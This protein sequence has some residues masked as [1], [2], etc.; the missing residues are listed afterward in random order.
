[1]SLNL[2]LSGGYPSFQQTSHMQSANPALVAADSHP[3]MFAPH[4]RL[5]VNGGYPTFQQHTHVHQAHNIRSGIQILYEHSSPGAAYNSKD[6]Y[7][8]P[9][10]HPNTRTGL[11]NTTRDWGQNGP[12]RIMWLYGS[13]G[14][15]KSAVAQTMS[16]EF[17]AKCNLAAS[18]FF[19]R[20]APLD[21]HRGHEGRFVATIAYQLTE[22]VP[23]LQRYVEQVV[24]NRPSVFDL[25]LSEQVTALII[26]PLK[27][28][29]LE[30]GTSPFM[31]PRVIVVDGLDE[32]KEESGQTQVLE[33]IAKLVSYQDI[34]PC[35]VFLA[36][37]PELVIRSWMNNKQSKLPHLLRSISLL[38]HCDSDHDI[39]V[40]VNDE[41]AEL[42]RSHPLTYLIPDDWPSFEFVEEIVKRASGQ[43]IYAST[44]MK[45]I[46]DLRGNP[47]DRLE[48]ILCNSIPSYDRP[49][50][51]LDALYL[52]IL[53]QTQY[54]SLV[55]QILAFRVSTTTF[56]CWISDINSRTHLQ[57]VLSLPF[58]VHTLLIDLQSILNY[59]SDDDGM[60]FMTC[61][62]QQ[63]PY[64]TLFHHASLL[65]FLLDPH[66]SEEF[67][68]DVLHFD[69]ELCEITL[70]HLGELGS[71]VADEQYILYCFL[72]LLQTQTSC[73]PSYRD[74]VITQLARWDELND[75]MLYVTLC[76]LAPKNA[77]TLVDIIDRNLWTAF[78]PAVARMGA[79]CY[80]KFVNAG[81][82][83]ELF[84]MYHT[85][86]LVLD[87]RR[88]LDRDL[89]PHADA[90]ESFSWHVMDC[91]QRRTGVDAWHFCSLEQHK[92]LMHIY[93]E[94]TW[95][96]FMDVLDKYLPASEKETLQIEKLQRDAAFEWKTLALAVAVFSIK[97]LISMLENEAV[98][99]HVKEKGGD[100][101][102]AITA[103]FLLEDI[104]HFI[105][106]Y[107]P[108]SADIVLALEEISQKFF[109]PH[110]VSTMEDTTFPFDFPHPESESQKELL[111]S[112]SS[113]CV[114]PR[115]FFLPPDFLHQT[116]VGM[117]RLNLGC[118]HDYIRL[119]I[120]CNGADPRLDHGFGMSWM[121][122]PDKRHRDDGYEPYDQLGVGACE[123]AEITTDPKTGLPIDFKNW[124][125][126][127]RWYKFLSDYEMAEKEHAELKKRDPSC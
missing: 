44:I 120:I 66:R 88:R 69:K 56:Y 31:L 34:F 2:T 103:A 115:W 41:A 18:F 45:Y 79:R 113:P 97:H 124:S 114:L 17:R 6:R 7:D 83:Q 20:T 28:L 33:A 117:I 90:R 64:P 127:E 70:Q 58:P 78:A 1:M 93:W 59:D 107:C 109:P 121:Y 9:K 13:A 24:L 80:Q 46:K 55:H 81:L 126:E 35:S 11:L 96:R 22:V 54:P 123:L 112:F 62:G 27:G 87:Y 118:L 3:A 16:M 26:D 111:R 53:R 36:S 23:G 73:H 38:D 48:A 74:K 76:Q 63:I 77:D 4:S 68:V 125:L 32:C 75:E 116:G 40:F 108:I 39:R 21:S 122:N 52:H 82:P 110:V 19:S 30:M 12:S 71:A 43:F 49:Y 92:F 60:Q 15:G 67:Y 29:Q 72:I 37:R 100:N 101:W 95:Q 10:C 14:A 106:Q 42:K 51:E 98:S 89:Q 8:P 86:I 47:S 65:E 25:T 105:W 99:E 94:P 85:S 5:M 91:I 84:V 104:S 57:I 102:R 119:S 50:A 61:E